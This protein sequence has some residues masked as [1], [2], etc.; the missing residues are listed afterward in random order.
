[1]ALLLA[2][3]ATGGC[4]QAVDGVAVPDPDW[5]VPRRDGP[6]REQVLPTDCLLT[7]AEMSALTGVAI[8]QVQPTDL[9]LT[10]GTYS[11]K[12]S[13]Y[14]TPTTG[15]LRRWTSLIATIKAVTPSLGGEITDEML[16]RIIAPGSTVLS[17]VG[18]RT[19]VEPV[20]RDDDF[21]VM[22]VVT[23]KYLVHVVLVAGTITA[24]PDLEGWRRAATA[25]VAALPTS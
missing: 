20:V 23:D 24:V 11:H 4:T 1:M 14:G 19:V 15:E 6:W 12:C 17:G 16:T 21:P 18:R 13:Y 7:P 9:R 22:R 8:T 25:V 5:T 3:V 10:D 2:L